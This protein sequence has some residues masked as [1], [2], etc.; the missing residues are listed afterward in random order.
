MSPIEY[1]NS[2]IDEVEQFEEAAAY[3]YNTNFNMYSEVFILM[4]DLNSCNINFERI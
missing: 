3:A 4:E 1:A 2:V